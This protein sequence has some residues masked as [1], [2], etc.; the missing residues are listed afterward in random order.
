MLL[1]VAYA[2]AKGTHLSMHSQDISRLP[3]AVRE[4]RV[5]SPSIPVTVA[6]AI[7]ALHAQNDHHRWFFCCLPAS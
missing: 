4:T 1:D 3:L 5:I 2:G 6:K 7:S